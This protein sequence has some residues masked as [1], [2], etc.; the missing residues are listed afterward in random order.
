MLPHASG[1]D[2]DSLWR[3][4]TSGDSDAFVALFQHLYSH[5]FNY[6]MKIL[7][8]EGGVEDGIQEI[9][10]ELWKRD[11]KPDVQSI[12]AY[13]LS[14]L[15]YNLMKKSGRQK[16]IY[17]SG[18]NVYDVF[19]ISREEYITQ[20]E[21]EKINKEKIRE[22]LTCLTPRQREIIFLKFNQG[23]S[24][25]EIS[26]IMHINYQAAR[27]LISHAIRALREIL[28]PLLLPALLFCT[29]H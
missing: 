18:E 1:K 27:N 8:D 29:I 16:E 26:G 10:L 13:L 6:G 3:Q 11:T 9:F 4:Y 7:P 19:D 12:K 5:M 25:E 14:S 2:G 28:V 21:T 23:L 17:T 22:A 15:R 24:Y 20:V